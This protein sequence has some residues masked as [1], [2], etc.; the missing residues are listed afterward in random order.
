MA[1]RVPRNGGA[2]F[3]VFGSPVRSR[4]R[5]GRLVGYADRLFPRDDTPGPPGTAPQ[6]PGR[7]EPR[8]GLRAAPGGAA[9]ALGHAWAVVDG[10]EIT[11]ADVE[12]AYRRTTQ[13]TGPS[14]EETST[15]S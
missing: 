5:Q 7:V 4:A 8:S 13:G 15:P 12:K 10:R 9:S 14:D 1:E 11:A 2:T 6:R 3:H